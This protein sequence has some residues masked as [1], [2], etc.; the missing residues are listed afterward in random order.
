MDDAYTKGNEL[1]DVLKKLIISSQMIS[2][3][4]QYIDDDSMKLI[5]KDDE[6]SLSPP[7]KRMKSITSTS[8]KKRERTNQKQIHN[9]VD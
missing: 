9:H 6:L 4:N 1:P 2:K 5:I 7:I 3:K 8:V